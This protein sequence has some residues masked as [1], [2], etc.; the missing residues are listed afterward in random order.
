VR[1]SLGPACAADGNHAGIAIRFSV[2]DERR[3]CVAFAEQEVT[4][5]RALRN[6]GLPVVTK[7]DPQLGEFV[8]KIGNVG[9]DLS[10]CPARDGSYWAYFK[11]RDRVW[12]LSGEGASSS[13]VQCGS[14]EG[15]AW[16]PRGVGAPPS[17]TSF[18]ELCPSKNCSGESPTPATQTPLEPSL[19]PTGGRLGSAPSKV[20]PS[21]TISASGLQPTASKDDFRPPAP[22]PS[23]AGLPARQNEERSGALRTAAVVVL[24]F[25]TGLAFGVRRLRRAY[26]ASS[27]RVAR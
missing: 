21:Q 1:S 17:P 6:T 9:T 19:S 24:A 13:K 2:D 8:C 16:S 7:V 15:W 22:T 5:I 20:K 14:G 27:R 26:E 10:D 3:Y 12:V 4:G 11:L 23:S 25:T 18:S